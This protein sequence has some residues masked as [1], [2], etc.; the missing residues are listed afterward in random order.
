MR[1]FLGVPVQVDARIDRI[2]AARHTLFKA[3]P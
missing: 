2:T 3:S 1:L